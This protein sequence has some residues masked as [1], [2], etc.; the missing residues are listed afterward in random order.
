[1]R[2]TSSGLCHRGVLHLLRRRFAV[3]VV[4]RCK[5]PA[6]NA[7][8][9]VLIRGVVAKVVTSDCCETIGML[10]SNIG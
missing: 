3:R 9:Y 10:L 7:T 5:S 4:A 6:T 2:E 1:M 8:R